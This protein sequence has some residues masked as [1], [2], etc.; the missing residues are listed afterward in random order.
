MSSKFEASVALVLCLLD[1]TSFSCFPAFLFFFFFLWS[2]IT[3]TRVSL[4]VLIVPTC[5]PL[6]SCTNSPASLCLGL[7]GASRVLPFLS[8]VHDT[9]HPVQAQLCNSVSV[10]FLFS[11]FPGLP[12][13]FWLPFTR[14]DTF[15]W[16]L[17]K[18][19]I[20]CTWVPPTNLPLDTGWM[21]LST[22]LR[23]R[24]LQIL[25]RKELRDWTKVDVTLVPALPC[26]LL[27]RPS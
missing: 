5:V 16:A 2:P 25:A 21:F 10:L 1:F 26:G 13:W 18:Y 22:V 9:F 24:K 8:R 12:L 7:V 20:V 17:S 3:F 6:P 14:E 11:V 19:F 27:P 15:C 23:C 4:S